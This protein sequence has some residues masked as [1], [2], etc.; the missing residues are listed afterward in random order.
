MGPI[1]SLVR[2]HIMLDLPQDRWFCQ[3]KGYSARHA[4]AVQRDETV[5]VAWLAVHDAVRLI[6]D[7]DNERSRRW[8]TVRL[9]QRAEAEPRE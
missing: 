4:A 6:V 2:R 1:V 7:P 9:H 3:L 5:M 8:G